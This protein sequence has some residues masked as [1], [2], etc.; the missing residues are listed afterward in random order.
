MIWPRG[1]EAKVSFLAS[2]VRL[3][4]C[5]VALDI[6]VAATVSAHAWPSRTLRIVAPAAERPA[7]E[8]ARALPVLYANRDYLWAGAGTSRTDIQVCWENPHSAP[9]ATPAERAAWR[10]VRRRAVEEWA[11]HAR[12]NFTGW[13]GDD[14]V[15][16][17]ATCAEKAPGL[18]VVIC[19]LP[20]DER[21]PA[22]PSSQSIVRPHNSGLKNGVRLN[23]DHGVRVVVHEFGHSL[24][25]YHEEERPDAP[26]V[27]SGRCA[28]QR[29][30]NARPVTY[31]AYDKNSIMAYCEP[32]PAA[33]WLSANDIAAV[34]RF[35]GRRNTH[36]LV[37]PRAKCAAAH[38]AAGSGDAVFLWDCDEAN[39]DQ[40]WIATALPPSRGD[41]WNFHIVGVSNPTTWCL[42]AARPA[43]GAAVQ[44]GNC[45]GDG[46]WRFEGVS[47]RGSAGSVSISNMGRWRPA[48]L[49]KRGPATRSAGLTSG[50]RAPMPDRSSIAPRICARRSVWTAG[51][52][53]PL[54]AAR[55]KPSCLRFR[56]APFADWTAR[57]VWTYPVRTT[58][59]IRSV[60]GCPPREALF[61]SSSAI[62]RSIRNGASA[63]RC[64]SVRIPDCA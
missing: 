10:D 44:L 17:P 5:V 21:C 39:R 6:P 42:V 31:G 30:P 12:V 45:S 46:G 34:Q 57:S 47:F 61:R 3:A 40:A 50:G 2:S 32:S 33:P 62:P 49:S 55:T 15:N 19:N 54:A 56:R 29:F 20:K 27:T 64:A 35:Y 53:S 36:S 60:Q 43:A 8:S 13:D 22:L 16:R 58:C 11:R 23:P 7:G 14:P 37:T 24:G 1:R 41:V 18:R 63:V 28:R 51:C 26:Q 38:H 25:F 48:R 9:G 4:A 52:G 59:N